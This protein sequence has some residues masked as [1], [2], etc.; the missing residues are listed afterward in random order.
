MCPL[1][2]RPPPAVIRRGVRGMTRLSNRF[3]KKWE[4]HEAMMSLYCDEPVL[5][6]LQFLQVPR[7][8]KDDAGRCGGAHGSCVEHSRIVGECGAGST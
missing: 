5:R 8:A 4:N 1:L 3:S 6:R 7:Y 2:F